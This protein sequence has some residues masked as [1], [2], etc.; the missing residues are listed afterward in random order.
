MTKKLSGR[1]D[2]G[3]EKDENTNVCM[4]AK[5]RERLDKCDMQKYGFFLRFLK[6]FFFLDTLF[7]ILCRFCKNT[8]TLTYLIISKLSLKD[9]SA[10][11]NNLVT[12]FCWSLIQVPSYRDQSNMRR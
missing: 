9:I 11:E 8:N 12:L 3:E 1:K 10:L 7:L 4:K 6:I 2:I 5:W